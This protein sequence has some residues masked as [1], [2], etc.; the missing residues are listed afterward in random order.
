MTRTTFLQNY[1]ININYIKMNFMRI[2]CFKLGRGTARTPTTPKPT[3]IGPYNG[4]PKASVSNL[5]V[6]YPN[7]VLG[8]FWFW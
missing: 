7:L 6:N 8:P 3:D 5:G 2:F 1:I 4:F